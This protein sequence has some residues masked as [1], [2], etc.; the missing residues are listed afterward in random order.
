MASSMLPSSRLGGLAK[1]QSVQKP[2][3]PGKIPSNNATP[4]GKGSSSGKGGEH[5]ARGGASALNRQ[6]KGCC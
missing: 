6:S 5:S 3:S 4:P 2:G 1:S